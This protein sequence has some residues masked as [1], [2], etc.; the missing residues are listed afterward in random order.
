MRLNFLEKTSK[1]FVSFEV[2]LLSE[3]FPL[4]DFGLGFVCQI[5]DL[6]SNKKKVTR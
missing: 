6:C 1:G 5:S 2:D 4:C 3:R